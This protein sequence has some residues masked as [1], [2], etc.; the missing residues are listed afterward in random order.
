MRKSNFKTATILIVASL[1]IS[2]QSQATDGYFSTGYG[3]INKGLA[4]T[5]IAFY[6]GSLINGNPAGAAFLGNK[7]QLGVNFFNPNRQYTVAGNPTPHGQ[8]T[9]GL[10]PGTVESDSKMFVIPSIGAN[11]MIGEKSAISAALFGNGGMNTYY[12]TTIFYDDSSESTG[13]NLGQMFG[14]ITYSLKLGEKHSLGV[15]GVLAYQYFEATG[16]MAF[17]GFSS[18]PQAISGNGKDSGFGYG[19]KIGYLG[20][21]TDNFAIGA[22]YQSKVTMGE[23]DDYAGLFA[24]QGNFDIPSSWTVGFSWEIVKDVTVMGDVKSIMY[25]DVKSISNPMMPNMYNA[26]MGDSD[27]LL[28]MDDGAGFGWE[29]IMV[30]KIGLNY[31]GVDTW[32]FRGGVSIGNN[33]VPESEVMF[34]ILAPGVIEN[35]VSLGLSKKVGK[36][37]NQF[38]LAMNYAFNSSVKGANPMDQPSGQTIEIEMNQFELELG[39]SF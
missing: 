33:P 19:F 35:Q 7:Y 34:N 37:G 32:E 23:L 17:G 30:Y 4:G 26:M 36:K 22:M 39:F 11:W 21:L 6:Q 10:M 1:F 20:H 5:G 15:T 3:T 27:Y 12:P 14:N 16:L 18:N 2:V 29:D 38:H 13:V 9:F 24:E 8:G 31:A 28:G 25:S